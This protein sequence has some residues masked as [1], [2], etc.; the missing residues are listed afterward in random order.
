MVL[1]LD[2]AA[3]RRAVEPYVINTPLL[4]DPWLTSRV[5]RDTYLKLENL[6]ITGS[7]KVRGA[8]NR[9][10]N[11]T[12]EERARGVVA[13]S[14]GNHGRAVAHV[15]GMLG[16]A[17]T[18]CVPDWADQ[19]K[20][21]AMTAAGANI[22]LAGSSYDDAAERAERLRD[23]EGLTLIHPFDDPLIVA[24]QGTIGTEIVDALPDVAEIVVPLSGGGLAGGLALAAKTRHRGV[25]ITA[26]S[27]ERAGVM[28][29]SLG[30]GKPIDVPEQPTI[31]NALAGGIGLDNRYTFVLVRDCV[32]QH[33]TVPEE[34]IID[35]MAYSLERLH[36]VVEGGGAV[37]LASVLS[38]VWT[39]TSE[40]GPL[41][42]LL[43]G[44]NV[45]PEGIARVMDH[46]PRREL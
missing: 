2:F 24:G 18:V 17:A 12:D 13:C 38:G 5:G 31:A 7:F 14:S 9:M 45:G 6:Q 33:C 46:T 8:V 3:A 25:T 16:M 34:A 32:D 41:V 26:A 27:A 29:A 39:A 15:A 35:A 11:L 10:L 42:I 23:D 36:M 22:I 44:G 21:A 20:L 30:A 37:A 43:S 1:H 40:G 19:V 28:L 4:L